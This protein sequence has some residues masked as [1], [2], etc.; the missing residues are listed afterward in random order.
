MVKGS[1][2]TILKLTSLFQTVFKIQTYSSFDD[3]ESIN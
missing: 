2:I 1:G 3:V